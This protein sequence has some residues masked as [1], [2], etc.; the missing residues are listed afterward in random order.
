MTASLWEG[1]DIPIAEAAACG[2]PAVAFDVG[3]HREVL[4]EGRLV[5]LKDGRH[6]GAA[7]VQSF[8]DAILEVLGK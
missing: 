8:A 7:D 4:K 3:S 6:A 5:T 2:R 1:F